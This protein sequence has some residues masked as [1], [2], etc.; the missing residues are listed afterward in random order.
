MPSPSPPSIVPEAD[1]RDIYLV[2]NDYGKL[3]RA[4]CETDEHWT[5]RETHLLDGRSVF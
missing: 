4:W 1:D 2:F 3:G 5:E